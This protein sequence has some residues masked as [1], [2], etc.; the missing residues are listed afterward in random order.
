MKKIL[1][2][3]EI[4]MIAEVTKGEGHTRTV[5]RLEGESYSA[6]V[7]GKAEVAELVD[8]PSRYLVTVKNDHGT[9][10]F[11]HVDEIEW[12]EEG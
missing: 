8:G 5:L 3:K 2:A 12:K 1:M 10:A 6:S 11:L 7:Y 4:K 9:V